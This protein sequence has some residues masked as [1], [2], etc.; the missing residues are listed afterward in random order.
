PLAFATD[1]RIRGKS[2]PPAGAELQAQEIRQGVVFEQ[3]GVRVTAFKGDHGGEELPAY[4]YRIDYNGRSA[5]LSRDTTF[6]ENLIHHATGVD[7]LVHEVTASR[8]I[9]DNPEQLKRITA[10]HTTP[11]QAGV[12]FQRA[13]PK[14]AVFTHLLLFGGATADDLVPATRKNYSG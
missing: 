11:E 12:V 10:N 2:Y 7:L 9:D 3:D 8:G 13:Q 4:G 5:V 1:L 14:L 6:N